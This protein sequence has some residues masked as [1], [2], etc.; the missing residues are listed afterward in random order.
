MET[1]DLES[2]LRL[3]IR[4]GAVIGLGGLLIR[5][6]LLEYTSWKNDRQLV[7]TGGAVV[8]YKDPDPSHLPQG[9]ASSS[10][11]FITFHTDSG[12][13]VKLYMGYQDYF[14]IEEGSRG[15]LTWQGQ[16]FWKFV[17]DSNA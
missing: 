5:F 3:L 2:I 14:L 10:V 4:A 16:K 17:P 9:R 12:E 11:Y 7:Q 1:Q 6:L 8:A 13:I 15:T